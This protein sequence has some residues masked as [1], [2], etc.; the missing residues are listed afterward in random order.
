MG[1]WKPGAKEFTVKVSF[2]DGRGYQL[3]VPKPVMKRLGDPSSLT[4]HVKGAR[5][6]VGAAKPKPA[7]VRTSPPKAA[8]SDEAK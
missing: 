3:Y 5:V 8:R 2:V 6:E 1:R 4:F 7:K